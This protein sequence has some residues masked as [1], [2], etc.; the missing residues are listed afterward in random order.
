MTTEKCYL[1][2]YISQRGDDEEIKIYADS[3]D[4]A[5]CIA[6]ETAPEFHCVYAVS[7]FDDPAAA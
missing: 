5:A 3:G 4:E 2:H 6:A 7:K 1:V